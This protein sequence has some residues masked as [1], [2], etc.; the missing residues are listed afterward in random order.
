MSGDALIVPIHLAALSV[1][2]DDASHHGTTGLLAGISADFSQLPWVDTAGQPGDP[3]GVTPN[4]G[5]EAMATPFA[6]AGIAPNAGIHL[7][8]A[9]PPALTRG[10]PHKHHDKLHFPPAPNRWLVVRMASFEGAAPRIGAWVVESDHLWDTPHT[11]PSSDP[12]APVGNVPVAATNERA[13]QPGYRS[14]GRVY[15]VGD[16]PGQG[17]YARSSPPSATGRQSTPPRTPIVRTS[18][19]STT[20]PTT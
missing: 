3:A 8:W 17:D 13:G 7:H 1:S 6:P 16:W 15:A 20:P 5:D 2:E 18:S 14:L 19:A 4:L 12:N 11:P 10:G 9:L